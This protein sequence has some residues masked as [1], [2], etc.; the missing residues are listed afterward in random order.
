MTPGDG[1]STNPSDPGTFVMNDD[2]YTDTNATAQPR[3]PPPPPL[4][5][6]ANDGGLGYV[7][8]G[9]GATG[10]L[11]CTVGPWLD[12]RTGDTA[13][14]EWGEAHDPIGYLTI[15][16]AE[17]ERI[18]FV[19][20]PVDQLVRIPDG[21]QPVRVKV[22]PIG[23]PDEP[24][25]S[26]SEQ[27][28]VKRLPPGGDD[29]DPSTPG[30]NE[31]LAA[32]GITPDPI[33]DDLSAV[34]VVV[35]TW[36]NFEP[37]DLL[38]V[39]WGGQRLPA[40]SVEGLTP[41]FRVRIPEA[42]IRKAGEGTISVTYSLRDRV[43]NVSLPSLPHTT[44]VAFD[45]PPV[46]WVLGTVD[47]AGTALDVD[48]LGDAD[49]G[50]IV[51]WDQL[52]TTDELYVRWRGTTADGTP[53]VVTTAA[54]KPAYPGAAV[55]FTVPNADAR[56]VI[57]GFVDV[58][59]IVKRDGIDRESRARH[60]TVTGSGQGE[61]FAIDPSPVTLS[62][63]QTF[64]R[65]ATGGTPP[66]RYTSAAPAVVLVT[67]AATGD[68]RAVAPGD[69]TISASDAASGQGAYLVHVTGSTIVLP[70]P[71]PDFLTGGTLPIGPIP[72][73][74]GLRVVVPAYQ[75]MAV[76]HVIEM[77]CIT[78]LG[79]HTATPQ[80]V[81]AIRAF[82]FFIPKNFVESLVAELDPAIAGFQYR[83]SHSGGETTSPRTDVTFVA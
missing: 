15:V 13:Y 3:I 42:V 1:V 69:T 79:T 43:Q 56:A 5:A 34:D 64:T 57:D 80:T 29:P 32:P 58:C 7:D 52:L 68:I 19:P 39:S 46:P 78:P 11:V 22:V 51:N 8:V 26:S 30:V 35:P 31:N 20:A 48:T 9:A 14:I 55:E 70:P 61:A 66:Y 25:Y 27:V 74:P 12:W 49:V 67:D 40:M 76:G 81:D 44:Q 82:E 62:E 65:K 53:H 60:L 17:P 72:E 6:A 28:L 21:L 37:T 59:Y 71:V 73:S 45:R 38:T 63:T 33:G 23:T 77:Q 54:K 16:D 24:F 18:Q 75:G 41:P 50:V 2:R 36:G 4:F 83:V 47:N 10:P